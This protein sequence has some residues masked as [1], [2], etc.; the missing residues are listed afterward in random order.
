MTPCERATEQINDLCKAT[1]YREAAEL[2]RSIAL[3]LKRWEVFAL[4][5]NLRYLLTEEQAAQL[6]HESMMINKDV[7]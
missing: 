6:T 5:D 3:P 4:N 7:A 2:H 1:L